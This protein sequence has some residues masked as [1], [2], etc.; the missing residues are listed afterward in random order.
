MK[1]NAHILFIAMMTLLLMPLMSLQ[2]QT[3]SRYRV[4]AC[5]WMMLKRQKLGE[6][7]LTK[8]IGADGVEMDMGGLGNRVLWDNQLR[9]SLGAHKFRNMADSLGVPVA[10]V[11]MSGFFAQSFLSR[12]NYIDLLQDCF[13]TARFFRAKVVFLPL[14]G[15]GEEW[16]N[17]DAL[18]SR[19]VERLTQAG[20]M[21]RA[22]GLTIGIRT[23]MD[24][25]RNLKLL[26]RI[27]SDG[28]KIYYN[29]QDACD[30][31]RDICKELRQLGRDNIIQIH[32]SNTDGV[33]LRED[34]E[35]DLPMIRKT[36]D[37]M[38]WT[39]WLVV[40]RS[41]DTTRVKDVKYN[42][43]RNVQYIKEVFE[44]R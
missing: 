17:D 22:N 9:D 16:K 21:A 32:C 5:D 23:G 1:T 36:L 42:F 33:N 30:N 41:R 37:K 31:N 4:A 27:A 34:P 43:S 8:D 12:D 20:M 2:A 29:L 10:S 38:K 40:E 15:C 19:M 3:T 28:I 35:I 13:N 18:Y 26:K 39:G 6:F 44:Q 24:A 14:G 7:Q 11:A 25:K